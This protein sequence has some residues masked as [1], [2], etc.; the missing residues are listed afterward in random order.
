M[1]ILV[2]GCTLLF[3]VWVLVIFES[4]QIAGIVTKRLETFENLENDYSFAVRKMVMQKALAI[5]DMEPLTGIGP[6]RFSHVSVDVDV[7]GRYGGKSM[8]N[9]DK[10]S[11]H[12]SYLGFLAEI[13]LV[14]ALPYGGLL[15]VLIF[16]GFRATTRLSRQGNEWVIGIY[17]SFIGLS[18]HL[19]TVSGL[20]STG[21]WLIYGCL[22]GVI[23]LAHRSVQKTGPA[24]R[25]LVSPR[26]SNKRVFN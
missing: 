11:P 12:N 15:A 9:F 22:A 1:R 7:E 8:S 21:P 14:G 10:Y 20:I 23:I 25:L 24:K 13:G 17:A 6:G 18:I 5:F 26:I 3:S 4:P 2:T 19:W 16:W